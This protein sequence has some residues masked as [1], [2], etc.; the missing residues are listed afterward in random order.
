MTEMVAVDLPFGYPAVPVLS[1]GVVAV[2]NAPSPNWDDRLWDIV[3]VSNGPGTQRLR[4]TLR[5]FP[6][7]VNMGMRDARVVRFVREDV[8]GTPHLYLLS[9]WNAEHKPNILL[10]Q[11]SMI[12]PAVGLEAILG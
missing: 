11:S 9:E 6:V 12:D 3:F 4:P 7:H 2:V 1:P 10:P 8:D 5:W